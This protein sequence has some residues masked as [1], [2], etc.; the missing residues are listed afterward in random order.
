[1]L[2]SRFLL[3]AVAATLVLFTLSAGSG[4]AGEHQRIH[5]SAIV[6]AMFGTTVEPALDGLLNIKAKM[7]KR[8]PD[9]P[10]KIAF[11]SNI[12]R[13]IWQKRATDPLYKKEHPEIPDEI[14]HVQGPLATLANLQDQ[15][16]DTIV[17]QPTHIA[18][19]EEFLDLCSYVEALASI[20]TI[21]E[22]F[23]PFNKLVVGRPALGTYGTK[24]PYA[25]DIKAAA[26]ALREDAELAKE[27]GAALVYMGHGNEFFPSGGSYLEF[28]AEMN[29]TYPDVLTLVGNVEGYPDFD[30]LLE[31]LQHAGVKRVVIKPM[32]VVAGDH[33]MN[34]MAGSDQGSWKSMLEKAGIEVVPVLRGLGQQDAFAEI[35]V[36]H[37]MDA[38]KDAGIELK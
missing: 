15:G 21:K 24:H 3:N 34:D 4:I 5:K 20:E 23:K 37:A 38:A 25:E 17:V 2:A 31:L 33:A 9:T 27:K 10:V 19:A 12:I 13:K 26:R 30:R 7:E 8:F 32:M 1:M 35:F 28:E 29:K 14:L 18:P 36:R 16:Y 22:R 11:T 6:L